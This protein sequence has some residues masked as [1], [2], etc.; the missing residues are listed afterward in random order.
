M[1]PSRSPISI[2][3]WNWA[4]VVL[5]AALIFVF[6]TEIFSGS[7][8]GGFVQA[9]LREFFPWLPLTE[10]QRIHGLIRKLGHFGE[11]LVFALLLMRALRNE[12]ADKPIIRTLL[13]SV[14]LTILY[15]ASDEFHQ[16]FVPNRSASVTD[17]MIDATG[18]ICGTLLSYLRNRKPNPALK[19]A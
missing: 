19:L 15:A 5:W 17:V 13:L 9:L 12:M 10:V 11:Y 7:Q 2:F 8:T 4:P 1:L 3:L 14:F 16:S 6:S 18:G